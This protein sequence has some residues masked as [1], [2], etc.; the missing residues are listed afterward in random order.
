MCLFRTKIHMRSDQGIAFDSQEKRSNLKSSHWQCPGQVPT[1]VAARGCARPLA[2]TAPGAQQGNGSTKRRGY[3][4]L[5]RAWRESAVHHATP[6][7]IC[8][9]R[10]PA[11]R[12]DGQHCGVDLPAGPAS[13]CR[14]STSCCAAAS[15]ANSRR[16]GRHAL[17][18]TS[19]SRPPTHQAGRRRRRSSTSSLRTRSPSVL[20]RR[21][22]GARSSSSAAVRTACMSRSGA[23]SL[24]STLG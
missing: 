2:G 4:A 9:C 18:R 17:G 24:S 5:Y 6:R 14:R 12:R 21:A 10:N 19:S 7:S 3:R 16:S 20:W 13:A 23:T 22:R 1:T 15:T 8:C 11:C